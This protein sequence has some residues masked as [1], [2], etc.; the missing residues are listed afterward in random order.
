[1]TYLCKCGLK[2]EV[3]S[4]SATTAFTDI[5]NTYPNQIHAYGE[6]YKLTCE[7][8]PYI[9]IRQDYR[10]G[11]PVN[12]P[13]VSMSKR[14]V[15]STTTDLNPEDTHVFRVYSLD[16]DFLHLVREYA[17]TLEGIAKDQF[18]FTNHPSHYCPDGRY[19]LSF[20]PEPNKKGKAAKQEILNRFFYP[21]GIRKDLTPEQEKEKVLRGIVMAR[22][23][24][25]GYDSIDKSIIDRVFTDQAGN[26]YRLHHHDENCGYNAE[27]APSG[28][29]KWKPYN[30][31]FFPEFANASAMFNV[32][33]RRDGL[34][35]EETENKTKEGTTVEQN[36]EI[37]QPGRSIEQITAEINFYKA[38]TAQNVIEIGK[39]LTEAKQQLQHGDWLPW[40]QDKVQFTVSTAERFMQ[41]AREFSNSAPVRNLPYT[42]LIAMLQ[43]PDE[44]REKFLADSHVVNG[45]EKTVDEMSK[46]ELAKAVKDLQEER[47]ARLQ[48]EGRAKTAQHNIE[49]LQASVQSLQDQ[50]RGERDT[51]SEDAKR[52]RAKL[53]ETEKQL[54]GARQAM[55][56]VKLRGDKLREENEELRS[57]P[58][59]VAVDPDE[60]ERRAAKKAEEL[61][62]N[63]RRQMEEL[64]KAK[65]AP[66]DPNGESEEDKCWDNIILSARV[67][68][69]TWG[70]AKASIKRLPEGGA[71]GVKEMARQKLITLLNRIEG[72][73]KCL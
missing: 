61:T 33:I 47:D 49:Q 35:P 54:E 12:K 64:Q 51:L 20:Y 40:L 9:C 45:E 68:D 52:I 1:M 28:S 44:D 41:V 3:P 42:K 10:N 36:T 70:I 22:M 13:E 65:S 62:A 11:K 50:L 7:G 26:R 72:E 18:A 34:Q 2:V 32:I 29:E 14:L 37:V 19:T 55:Q 15:Y 58:V 24:T 39:R 53:T 17:D 73:L 48:A 30:G 59:E 46:R 21:D 43:V 56:A 8:C 67:I 27:E 66:E 31:S 4:A 38:Q 25:Q 23:K 6:T 16:F 63:L 71:A 69:D 5:G 57:R 60:I